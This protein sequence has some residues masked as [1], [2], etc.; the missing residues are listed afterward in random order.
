MLSEGVNMAKEITVNAYIGGKRVTSL[1]SEQSQ[2][3]ARAM[4]E[5]LSVYYSAH[6]EEY[7][8]LIQGGRES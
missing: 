1:S 6:P 7:K 3:M 8:T 2:N 5:A 4:S